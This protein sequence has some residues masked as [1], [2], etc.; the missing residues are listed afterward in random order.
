MG[1]DVTSIAAAVTSIAGLFIGKE[2]WA[3][4]K[5]KREFDM[6]I[7]NALLEEKDNVIASQEKRIKELEKKK[8]K[9]EK[10]V[11]K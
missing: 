9:L 7:K 4:R 2:Y 3:D 1:A 8:S 10:I 6:T 5:H 11:G